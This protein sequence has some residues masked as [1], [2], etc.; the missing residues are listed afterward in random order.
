MLPFLIRNFISPEI[1]NFLSLMAIA[2][3]LMDDGRAT[4]KSV[5]IATNNFS[6]QEI[7]LFREIF[8]SKYNLDCTVQLLFKKG[9]Q[10]P[11][12]KYSLYIKR[13]SMPKLREMVLPYMHPSILYKFGL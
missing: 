10:T 5:R 7:E 6:I 9:G 11:K 13:T 3:L 8:K 4:S 2:H 1:L 12:D